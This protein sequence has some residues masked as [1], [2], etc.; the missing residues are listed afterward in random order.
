MEPPPFYE[1]SSVN[2]TIPRDVLLRILWRRIIFRTRHL[3]RTGVMLLCGIFFLVNGHGYKYFGVFLLG[4]C[5]LF[6]IMLYRK[7][8]RIID[9][10]S[11]FTDPK[12]VEFSQS[13]LIVVGPNWKSEM[14][15][16]RF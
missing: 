5:V 15:W 8:G 14:P 11:Q 3:V 16:T 4:L 13:R 6:P 10:N 7:L 12:T 9:L 2:Y 1:S